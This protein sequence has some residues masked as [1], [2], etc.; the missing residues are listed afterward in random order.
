MLNLDTALEVEPHSFLLKLLAGD[1]KPIRF[2]FLG[3]KGPG[4]SVLCGPWSMR[5]RHR[6]F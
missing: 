3:M 6:R 5:F 2:D 1:L 4:S